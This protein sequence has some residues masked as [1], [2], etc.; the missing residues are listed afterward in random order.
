MAR[1]NFTAASL[2][3]HFDKNP[4]TAVYDVQQRGLAAYVTSTGQ[5]TFFAHFRVGSRQVKKTLARL[6][7]L[8]VAEARRKVATLVI[9]GQEGKD[10]VGDAR[11][12]QERA[13]TLGEIFLQHRE[14]MVRRKCSPASIA[15][16]E[17]VWRARLS[18]YGSRPLSSFTKTEV[19]AMHQQWRSAG[20]CA[21][22]RAIRLL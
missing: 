4:R 11:R 22:N 14:F 5:I 15:V 3:E 18:K 8:P 16:N 9:A 1:L 13:V 20:P 2:R 17:G 21:A 10:V 7:E 19:R 12:A 6:S